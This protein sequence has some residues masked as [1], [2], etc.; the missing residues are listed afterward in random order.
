M[1]AHNA[2]KSA[3]MGRL[4]YRTDQCQAL[5]GAIFSETSGSLAADISSEAGAAALPRAC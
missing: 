2:E 1:P 4:R 5:A 3:A